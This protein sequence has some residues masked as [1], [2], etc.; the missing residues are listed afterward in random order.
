M[1]RRTRIVYLNHTGLVS[2]AERV[3]IHMLRVLDRSR[4]EAVVLCP[5]N[6]PLPGLVRD[7][8]IPCLAAPVIEGRFTR[9]PGEMLRYTRSLGRSIRAMRK[10]LLELNPDLVHANTLR[11]GVVA[12]LATAGADLPVVWHVHDTLPRHAVSTAIRMLALQSRRTRIVAVS[13]AAGEAFCGKAPLGGRLRVI[14]N[15]IDLARFPHKQAGGAHGFRQSAGIPEEAFLV[16]AVGQI[17]ARK[18]LRELL[19]SF[20]RIYAAA[21]QMHLA[22]V[23]KAVFRHEEEYRD[24]LMNYVRAAGIEDRVHFTG[25]RDDVSAAMQASDLL[26]LNSHEEP[27]GLVLV[28]AMSSGTP[29]VATRVGGIPEIVRDGENGWLVERGDCAALGARLLALSK[30]RRSLELAAE[31]AYRTTCPRF[32]LER[33]KGDL[34]RFYAEVERRPAYRWQTTIN[35]LSQNTAKTKES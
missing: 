18:G 27:F 29:V 20:R 31:T 33:F 10:T 1:S 30:D 4:Y 25:E 12:T 14:H 3:L 34:H 19:E 9:Q 7:E 28:E 24:S 6:G 8:D 23:G 5:E 22:I 35:L 32:S 13:H 2:G 21:P 17:C 15:G 26:V 16:S 11:A